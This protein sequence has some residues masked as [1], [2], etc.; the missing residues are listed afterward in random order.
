MGQLGHRV[1]NSLALKI[2]LPVSAV[3]LLLTVLSGTTLYYLHESL[4][5]RWHLEDHVHAESW[6][7]LLIGGGTIFLVAVFTLVLYYYLLS[8]RHR[9]GYGSPI[10]W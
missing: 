6:H 8:V 5:H 7:V 1:R 3:V 4:S 9:V 10:S 2:C